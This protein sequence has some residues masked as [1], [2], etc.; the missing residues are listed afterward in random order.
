MR[1][2]LKPWSLQLC[3]Y[4][5]VLGPKRSNED[6]LWR[7]GWNSRDPGNIPVPVRQAKGDGSKGGD[8]RL[9][10]LV[11]MRMTL[12]GSSKFWV[13]ILKWNFV[14]LEELWCPDFRNLQMCGSFDEPTPAMGHNLKPWE[15]PRVAPKTRRWGTGRFSPVILWCHWNDAIWWST[16]KIYEILSGTFHCTLW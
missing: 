8:P 1:M 10:S 16:A 12:G 13:S 9:L 5:F 6:V 2:M 7:P 4:G 11:E 15:V 14:E 3:P